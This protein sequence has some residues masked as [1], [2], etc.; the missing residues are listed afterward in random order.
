MQI[1]GPSHLHGP[2]GVS[3][4]H[5]RSS[6]RPSQP[7][8][9]SIAGDQLELSEAGQAAARL[10]EAAEVRHDR[11]AQIRQAIAEGTYATDEKLNIALD[12]LLDE[13]G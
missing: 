4:P 2:Q 6:L 7:G 3:P 13:I 1:Y 12:R 11:V 5:G 10:A 9:T 8:P